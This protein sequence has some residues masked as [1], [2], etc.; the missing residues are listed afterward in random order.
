MK[1]R[2]FTHTC[3][4]RHQKRPTRFNLHHGRRTRAAIS[5]AAR[6]GIVVAA[7]SH[8]ALVAVPLLSTI[9]SLATGPS[10]A[11]DPNT[12]YRL[13]V[14]SWIV[15][16]ALDTHHDRPVKTVIITLPPLDPDTTSEGE[17]I[18]S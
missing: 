2:C 12:E 10:S 4:V 14:P 1:I 16:N 7:A 6:R 8:L 5:Q 17:P 9:S 13:P 3:Q 18:N 15:V 11:L